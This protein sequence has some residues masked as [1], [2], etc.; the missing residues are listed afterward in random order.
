MGITYWY[1]NKKGVLNFSL[2]KP[3]NT[4]YLSHQVSTLG[5]PTLRAVRYEFN[6]VVT[7]STIPVEDVGNTDTIKE[8]MRGY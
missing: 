1:I 6:G 2:E 3:D 7:N 8:I 4:L 5:I